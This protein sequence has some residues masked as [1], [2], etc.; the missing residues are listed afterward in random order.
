MEWMGYVVHYI[1]NGEE[2]TDPSTAYGATIKIASDRMKELLLQGK[3]A[4]IKTMNPS[5]AKEIPF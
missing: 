5:E 1:H 4:W 2:Y 3:C